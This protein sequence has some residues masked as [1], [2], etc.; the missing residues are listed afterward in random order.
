MFC[1]FCG[2][3][4]LADSAFC[5]KCGKPV[6][7]DTEST[8]ENVTLPKFKIILFREAQMYLVN[9]PIN[10]AVNGNMNTSISNGETKDLM[11][12]QGHYTLEF[13]SSM[14][15]SKIEVD[16]TKNIQINLTWS[17]LTGGIVAK[18]IDI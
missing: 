3:Q 9:P 16:L 12:E 1:R 13:S 2:N 6:M 15:K 14:R 7:Q 18:L 4:I 11:L 5:S 17:R 10:I 8:I